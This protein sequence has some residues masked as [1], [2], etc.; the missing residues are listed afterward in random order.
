[1]SIKNLNPETT[2]QAVIGQV[3]VKFRKTLGVDQASIAKAV[4]V[5][6]STWSRIERGESSL[7][8]EQ[9]IRASRYLRINASLILLEAEK[10]ITE[11]KKQ[12]VI[13]N[14]NKLQENKSSNTGAALIGAAALGVI[15]G[16]IITKE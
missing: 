15:V 14:F 2:F 6:Q 9:L 7:S 10:A 5:T 3:I 4:G 13:I 8:I 1:M 16:A 12:G 11:L